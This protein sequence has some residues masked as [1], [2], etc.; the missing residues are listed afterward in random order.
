MDIKEKWHNST[1]L[2]LLFRPTL[3]SYYNLT[4]K[5]QKKASFNWLIDFLFLIFLK[6]DIHKLQNSHKQTHLTFI[7]ELKSFYLFYNVKIMT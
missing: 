3:K 6:C 7:L 1:P 4:I 5:S 2:P